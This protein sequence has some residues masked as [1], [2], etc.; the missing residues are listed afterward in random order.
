MKINIIRSA[1]I[2]AALCG[3]LCLGG[4]KAAAQSCPTLAISSPDTIAFGS[5]LKMSVNVSGGGTVK[6]TYNWSISSGTITSGQGTSTITIEKLGAGEAVTGTVEVGGF[7][8]ACAATKSTTTIVDTPLNKKIDEFGAMNNTEDQYARLDNLSVE[9]NNDPTSSTVL[10]FYAGR[11]SRIGAI[12]AL[13]DQTKK[14][15]ITR[16][17]AASRILPINGGFREQGLIEMW[18]VPANGGIPYATPT[19]DPS[20]AKQLP[21]LKPKPIKKPVKKP[22]K[23]PTTK[24]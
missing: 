4:S 9:M 15:L 8:R 20:E 19:V 13:T 21:A 5:S 23:K 6:P 12:E 18:L 10:L 14:Y 24:S 2:C 3:V 11:T 1:V 17:I 16:G 22:V 7:D